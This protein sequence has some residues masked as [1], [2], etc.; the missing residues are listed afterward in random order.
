MLT[1][2]QS[3]EFEM[4]ARMPTEKLVF[5]GHLISV[6]PGAKPSADEALVTRSL[7]DQ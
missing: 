2:K 3:N 5:T 7:K 4:G 6:K 1:S